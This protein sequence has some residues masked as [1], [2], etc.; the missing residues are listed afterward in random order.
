M[1]NRFDRDAP[2]WDEKN[3]RLLLADD[4]SQAIRREVEL[5]PEMSV[6]DFGC[7][8]GLVSMPFA[9]KVA[10]LTGVDTSAGMLTVFMEK[11]RAS[12]YTHVETLNRNLADG[13]ELP[14]TYDLIMSSM[15]FHHV[16]DISVVINTLVKALNPGGKLCI[17]D[18]DPDFGLFHSDNTGVHHYGFE[19]EMVMDKFRSAGL[20]NVHAVTAKILPRVGADNIKREFSVFLITGEKPG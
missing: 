16:A 12:G 2:S 19:R 15:T 6:L 10:K 13:D 8:T 1:N 9:P 17:A 11:A 3:H 18:L 5:Y 7:G 4:V 20:A 14:G